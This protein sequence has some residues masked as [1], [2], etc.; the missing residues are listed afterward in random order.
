M[1]EVLIVLQNFIEDEH[2]LVTEA[3]V[4]EVEFA[5][6]EF[7]IVSFEDVEEADNLLFRCIYLKVGALGHVQSN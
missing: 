1:G 2:A 6:L 7:G 5:L 4:G 3:H